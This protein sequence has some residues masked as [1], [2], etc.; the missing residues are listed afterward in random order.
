MTISKHK[1]SVGEP[2]NFE[3]RDGQ[4][5]IFAAGQ[6]FLRC[7]GGNRGP[8]EL[9][10][11]N[12]INPFLYEGNIVRQLAASTRYVGDNIRSL[13]EN[14][15]TANIFV[16]PEAITLSPGDTVEVHNLSRFLIGSVE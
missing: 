13:P 11:L 15:I 5:V 4:N 14:T 2:W 7:E 3:S 6:G 12:V 9:F 8:F 10:L 1:I 16:I